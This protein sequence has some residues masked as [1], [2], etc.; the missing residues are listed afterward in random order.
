MALYS[1]AN[2]TSVPALPCLCVLSSQLTFVGYSIQHCKWR[3]RR[4]VIPDGVATRM[5]RARDEY[6]PHVWDL[7]FWHS[8]LW[9]GL[10]G[11]CEIVRC[12][13]LSGILGAK[14]ISNLFFTRRDSLGDIKRKTLP[15]H[16]FSTCVFPLCHLH[17]PFIT[18][19]SFPRYISRVS[20]DHT[21]H[22]FENGGLTR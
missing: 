3:R 4:V 1:A 17:L 2:L 10:E 16:R 22:A 6:S 8:V 9:P 13:S 12:P 19:P 20:L 15:A 5:V 11:G 7:Y 14:G 18:V 21:D